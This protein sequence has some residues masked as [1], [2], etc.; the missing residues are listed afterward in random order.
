MKQRRYEIGRE[1]LNRIDG[2]DGEEVIRSLEDIA[3]DIGTYIVEFA[4]GDIYA[5][6]GLTLQEK[7]ENS[8]TFQLLRS[9]KISDT[10]S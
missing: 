7:F 1:Q 3:P 10:I 6:K 8:K 2:A 4:F 5:R 9:V